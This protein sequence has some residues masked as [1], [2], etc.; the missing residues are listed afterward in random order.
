MRK[1]ATVLGESFMLSSLV[2]NTAAKYPTDLKK[3]GWLVGWPIIQ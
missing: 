1:H 2:N 3:I